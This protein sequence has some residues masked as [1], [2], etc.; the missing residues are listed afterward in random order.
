MPRQNP[1]QIPGI[2]QA[3]AQIVQG[4]LEGDLGHGVAC[5]PGAGEEVGDIGVQP[6]I[7]TT[8]PPEPKATVRP[9]ITDEIGDGLLDTWPRLPLATQAGGQGDLVQVEE[10][11]GAAGNLLG[12]AEGIAIQGLEQTRQV[13]PAGAASGE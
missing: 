6:E 9:L 3:V 2:G 7:V 5:L 12:A 13:Q 1:P 8:G 4:Q 10:R 11:Q